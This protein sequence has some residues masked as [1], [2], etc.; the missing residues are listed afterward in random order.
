MELRLGGVY[1]NRMGE[2]KKIISDS[3][4]PPYS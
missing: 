3:A 1:K 2:V 4:A